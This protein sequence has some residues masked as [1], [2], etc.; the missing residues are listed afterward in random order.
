MKKTILIGGGIIIV[1]LGIF[2]YTQHLNEQKQAQLAEELR[3]EEQEKLEKQ[4]REWQD[5][6][7]RAKLKADSAKAFCEKNNLRTDYCI[8]VDFKIHSGK[9]RLFVWDFE[10]DT[11]TDQNLCCHGYGD[12]EHRSSQAD[13]VFSNTPGSLCSSLGKFK[14]AHRDHCS[15]GTMFQY[16]LNGLED[17]NNNA[18][19]RAV[20]LHSY[21]AVPDEEIYPKH[22]PLGY[23]Q[24]C[25]IV[26]D[27]M[28]NRLDNLMK[29]SDKKM[30]IW[31]YYN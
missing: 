7:N 24:G 4:Q 18:Y 25:F 19:P 30:L 5:T 13:I 1:L 28:M 27:N 20:T 17:T 16:R 23:S 26:S 12:K 31:S 3:L 9:N 15:Y 21:I 29:M 8:L 11:I 22:I 2:F 6:F 10:K 14:T